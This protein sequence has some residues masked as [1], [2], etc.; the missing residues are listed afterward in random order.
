M[1]QEYRKKADEPQSVEIR[2]K[3]AGLFGRGGLLY[4]CAWG[5]FFIHQLIEAHANHFFQLQLHYIQ[6][7]L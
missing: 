7:A 6:V 5:L 4:Q 2:K 1:V 3:D